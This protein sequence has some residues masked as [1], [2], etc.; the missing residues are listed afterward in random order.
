MSLLF[1]FVLALVAIYMVLASLFNSLIHP[2]TIMVSAPMS[3]IGGFLAMKL[4]GIHLDMM[5][6]IGFL[7]LMGLVM[8]NGI[9]LVDHLSA[10]RRGM[11]L[12]KLLKARKAKAL[13]SA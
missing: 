4:T 13:K 2:L 5:S 1:A 8:K 7:V 10:I 9:L 11:I 12:R 6:G 3:F